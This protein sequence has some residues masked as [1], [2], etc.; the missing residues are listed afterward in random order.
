MNK[1]K[2]FTQSHFLYKN[3]KRRIYYSSSFKRNIDMVFNIGNEN[4]ILNSHPKNLSS[5]EKLLYKKYYKSI[6]SEISLIYNKILNAIDE[7]NPKVLLD[8]EY[9]DVRLYYLLIKDMIKYRSDL[10]VQRNHKEVTYIEPVN[11][12]FLYGIEIDRLKN[13]NK[14]LS[15]MN[16]IDKRTFEFVGYEKLGNEVSSNTDDYKDFKYID[17]YKYIMNNYRLSDII[18][19]MKNEKTSELEKKLLKNESLQ[20][21][22]RQK[23][24]SHLEDENI[25][26]Y[27]SSMIS[28]SR[29]E[30]KD[31]KQYKAIL[32]ENENIKKEVNNIFDNEKKEGDSIDDIIYS[33]V[34]KKISEKGKVNKENMDLYVF[35][36]KERKYI[37][38]NMKKIN[39]IDYY[40]YRFPDEYNEFYNRMIGNYKFAS[41][42][43]K[44]NHNNPIILL[45]VAIS[46][47][48]RLVFSNKVEK[49][50]ENNEEKIFV[51]QVEEKKS[52]EDILQK[53]VFRVEFE[54][55]SFFVCLFRQKIK[56][57]VTDIDL[58]LEGNRHF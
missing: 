32:S 17:K 9:I 52:I 56:I 29:I 46:S 41:S 45:D 49:K 4:E 38:E 21:K 5:L 35:F 43:Y 26:Y 7:N 44:T 47:N 27:L 6:L 20:M 8:N 23:L 12:N 18:N 31:I 3:Q 33:W 15:M 10:T 19:N 24:K 54:K 58:A 14:G 1:I 34:D 42:L 30:D 37:E 36:M 11:I 16:Q 51:F 57:K 13:M 48:K 53:H 50:E 55:P 25:I 2:L 22:L 39:L 40:K 28:K